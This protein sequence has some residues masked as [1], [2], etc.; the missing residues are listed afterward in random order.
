MTAEAGTVSHVSVPDGED[1]GRWAGCLPAAA[2][3]SG[4]LVVDGLL[5]PEQ[6]EPV[7]R[8]TALLE[9]R[10][11]SLGGLAHGAGA[12]PGPPAAL[13]GRRREAE[14]QALGL[15]DQLPAWRL[16]R[17]QR[18]L[19]AAIVDA[20][21]GLSN[22]V[23][24]FVFSGLDAHEADRRS[25]ELLAEELATRG[26]TVVVVAT[27]LLHPRRAVRSVRTHHE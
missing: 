12:R 21:L 8:R 27:R 24:L 23:D 26:A 6:R 2:A 14:R 5:L 15:V 1:P 4:E 10:P 22:D 7:L 17:A 13:S 20:A 9:L 11:G 18:A 16:R 19:A 25:A 3:A